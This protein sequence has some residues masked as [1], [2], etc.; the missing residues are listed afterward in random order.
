MFFKSLKYR[1]FIINMFINSKL[2]H[3]PKIN[4]QTRGTLP[5]TNY[6]TLAY[7]V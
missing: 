4:V 1:G 5:P 7:K 6:G 2:P 3:Y